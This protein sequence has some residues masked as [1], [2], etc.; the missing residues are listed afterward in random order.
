[1]VSTATALV[2]N[3]GVT[4]S[5]FK[6]SRVEDLLGA[7]GAPLPNGWKMVHTQWAHHLFAIVESLS[8]DKW[9]NWSL[10]L[11]SALIALKYKIHSSGFLT[12]IIPS[13]MSF[14]NLTHRVSIETGNVHPHPDAAQSSNFARI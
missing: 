14:A 6:E 2:C 8:P 5:T 1:M 11:F 12:Y 7:R 10:Q 4:L 9:N 13:G 3:S